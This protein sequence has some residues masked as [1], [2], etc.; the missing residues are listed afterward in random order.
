MEDEKRSKQIGGKP[1][2][3]TPKVLK[4]V[5][6]TL[7]DESN[8]FSIDAICAD[9]VRKFQ[10]TI[11]AQSMRTMLNKSDLYKAN[12]AEIKDKGAPEQ[13]ETIPSQRVLQLR[14][15]AILASLEAN[16]KRIHSQGIT[17]H[18]KDTAQG[19][20]HTDR[21]IH[22]TMQERPSGHLLP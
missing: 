6:R 11:G 15:L 1:S 14:L 7:L 12:R 19:I 17:T 3:V 20:I 18:G 5:V 16:R 9:A 2:Q 8:E 22:G 4:Y 21:P 10:L 13:A